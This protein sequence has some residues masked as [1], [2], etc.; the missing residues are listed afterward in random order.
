MTRQAATAHLL[1]L[2]ER[3]FQLPE[4]A[5]LEIRQLTIRREDFLGAADP[6]RMI[7]AA[8]DACWHDGYSDIDMKVL[9]T[10]GPGH[11]LDW[12]EPVGVDEAHCLGFFMVP[13]SRACRI[14]F[15]EGFPGWTASLAGWHRSV[16]DPDDKGN[17][18]NGMKEGPS[19]HGLRRSF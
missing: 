1:A 6:M 2:A 18:I 14:V 13:E 17:G 7:E 4:C 9:A 10:G 15:R 8:M 5:G 12:L 16:A 11:P 3:L 19:R